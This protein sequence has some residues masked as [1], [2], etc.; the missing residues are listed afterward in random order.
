MQL[1]ERYGKDLIRIAPDSLLT[2]DP[3]VLRRI[4]GAHN[5]YTKGDW[6]AVM[7]LDLYHH[8]IVSSRDNAFHDDIKARTA[9][10]YSGR[11]V[12]TMESDIDEQIAELK[13]LITREYVSTDK[14]YK[15]MDW[16][17]V[18]EHFT[19]DSLMKVAF[20]E[21]LG[22]LATNSDVHDYIKMI[23]AMGM[24]FALC[25]DV[26]WLG[27]VLFSDFMMRLVGPKVGDKKGLGA[28]MGVAKKM[29]DARFEGDG[30]NQQDMMGSF[31]HHGIPRRQCQAELLALFVAG[32][33]ATAN[34]LRVGLFL[35]ITT[36][37]VYQR[38]QAEIDDAIASGRISSPVTAAQGKTLPYLQAFLLEC[39]R[40]SPPASLPL[41]KVVP[42]QGDTLNGTFVP[43][44]TKIA[45]DIWSLGRRVDVFGQDAAVFRPERFLEATS[46][47]RAH[48]EQVTDLIF[49]YGRYMC[50]GKTMAWLEMNKTFV[51]VN[52]A[53]W[54]AN[55]C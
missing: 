36:P 39:L 13:T 45:I 35:I 24:F 16:G 53:S 2:D 38:L 31:I 15:P 48:M 6:Y 42:P 7:R 50:P 33:D 47:K 29:V 49:G 26:P 3:D 44:G 9:A 4:N 27:R 40:F 43:G 23:E 8:T 19:L 55:G 11:D 22:D 14:V 18:A 41:P 54:L 21:P 5:G 17:V 12:P 30:S 32:S 20:G 46:G 51:E 37:G 52:L 25:G 10:G 34:L 28:I 1:R